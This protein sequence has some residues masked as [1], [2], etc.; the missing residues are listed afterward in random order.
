MVGLAG[1]KVCRPTARPSA[2]LASPFVNHP[3]HCGVMGILGCWSPRPIFRDRRS[4]PVANVQVG[5]RGRSDPRRRECRAEGRDATRDQRLCSFRR[6]WRR[7]RW[8]AAAE[9]AACKKDVSG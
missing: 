7:R 8:H 1:H 4:G 6:G 2:A 5:V 3:S 9:T